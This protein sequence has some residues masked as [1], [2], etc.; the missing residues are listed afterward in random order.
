MAKTI[1]VFSPDK[2]TIENLKHLPYF[3]QRDVKLEVA[4]A[5]QTNNS[6]LT[7]PP[8]KG[9]RG[10]YTGCKLLKTH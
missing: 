5:M 10:M 6:N 2:V 7:Y 3:C 1:E 8:S 9:A 4:K